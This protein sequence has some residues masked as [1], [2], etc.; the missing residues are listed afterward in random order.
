MAILRRS[1]DSFGTDPLPE[2]SMRWD[3]AWPLFVPGYVGDVPAGYPEM[4]MGRLT[5][6]AWDVLGDLGGRMRVDKPGPIW[7]IVPRLT[8]AGEEFVARIPSFWDDVVYWASDGTVTGENL[9]TAPAVNIQDPDLSSPYDVAV[10]GDTDYGPGRERVLWP[11]VGFGRLHVMIVEVAPGDA[12]TRFHSRTAVDEYY[13][14]LS[15]RATLRMGAHS[16]PV[17]PGTLIGK[18]TDP[19]LSSQILAD[20]GEP[21]TILDLEAWPDARRDTKDLMG[22]WEFGEFQL[23]GAGWGAMVPSA[24]LYS[25]KHRYQHYTSGY[26]LNL[27]GKVTA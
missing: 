3:L 19:D 12:S 2:A 5:I 13:F 20:R 18:P 4:T 27:D 25:A 16:V 17:E 21:V 23:H 9:W 24:A 1:I 10:K 7:F 22:Y 11:H 15:G 6:W 26:W 14:I 8:P